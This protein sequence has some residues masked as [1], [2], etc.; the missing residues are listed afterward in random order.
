MHMQSISLEAASE[1]YSTKCSQVS[2][3]FNRFML[4]QYTR[5]SVEVVI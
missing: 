5:V 2:D 3:V 1:N 4:K